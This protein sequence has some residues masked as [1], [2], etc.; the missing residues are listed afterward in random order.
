MA[1]SRSVRARRL[2]ARAAS[3]DRGAHAGIRPVP[4]SWYSVAV[5]AAKGIRDLESSKRESDAP[6]RHRPAERR[7]ASTRVN[8]Q[9]RFRRLVVARLRV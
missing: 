7:A 5:R 1:R 8:E 6:Q 9:R 3:E 4:T 2:A